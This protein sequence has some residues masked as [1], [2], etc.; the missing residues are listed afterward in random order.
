MESIGRFQRPLY[1]LAAIRLV[2]GCSH[3]VCLGA[4]DE[5][6]RIT[7]EEIA[8]LEEGCAAEREISSETKLAADW[9]AEI[10]LEQMRQDVVDLAGRTGAWDRGFARRDSLTLTKKENRVAAIVLIR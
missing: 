9:P 2:S 6:Q 1:K 4:G 3:G 10:R 8:G 5:P 7:N